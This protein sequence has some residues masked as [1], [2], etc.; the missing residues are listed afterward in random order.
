MKNFQGVGSKNEVDSGFYE[1]KKHVHSLYEEETS[2]IQLSEGMQKFVDNAGR[3]IRNIDETTLD[4]VDDPLRM[5]G[6]EAESAK[7]RPSGG[8]VGLGISINL[9][10]KDAANKKADNSKKSDGKEFYEL[11]TPKDDSKDR[12]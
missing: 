12:N 4:I 7:L 3:T 1:Q 6:L 11:I 2:G 10:G 5:F 8:G 9:E